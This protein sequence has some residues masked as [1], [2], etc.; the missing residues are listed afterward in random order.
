VPSDGSNERTGVIGAGVMGAG[1]AQVLAVA[2]CEV[3]LHDVD[4]DA[5]ARAEQ[6]VRRGRYGLEATVA[7]G[8]LTEDAATAALTRLRATTELAEAA[9][10]DLVLEAVP[11]RLDLKLGVFRELDRLAPAGTI[12]ASNSSGL[13]IAALAAATERPELVI[14]WHWAS[15]PVVM[16]LAEI[17]RTPKT[18][19]ATVARVREL[20]TRAGKRPVVVQ[21][22]PAVW[23]Y[24]ANRVYAAAR[25]EAQA[26]VD[27][28]IATAEEVDQLMV[29]AF[30]W[31][32]GPFGMVRGATSGWKGGNEAG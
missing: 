19:E 7:R 25:A 26:V 17:V 14:G 1:I 2:G 6:E 13:P 30:R 12:L 23:G 31:P 29:D 5:L 24:V 32:V 27:A 21:D 9:A 18:S 15:P 3:V 16:R 4:A 10:T 28:G 20:A 8:T 22:H 11:E